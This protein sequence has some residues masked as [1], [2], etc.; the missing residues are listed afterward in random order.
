MKDL[1][2]KAKA[3]ALKNAISYDGKA[4]QGA[5]ISGLF[6][7]GLK[8][9]DVKEY[10]KDILSAIHEVNELSLDD[11]KI[12]FEKIKEFVSEREI[13][14][15]LIELPNTE[16]VIMRFS[17]SPSGALHIGHALTACLNFDYSEKYDGK[18]YVRI[19]DTNPENI[20]KPAYKLIETD[21]DWLFDGKAEIIIQSDRIEL[22]YKYAKELIDKGSAY[23]C[24]CA[25]EDFKNFVEL[26]EDCPC[27]NNEKEEN[28]MR[29]D[30]MLLEYKA[31]EAV[32]RFKS[33]LGMGDPNPAMRDFPLAR[34][35]E[36]THARQGKKYRV[37]PLMN[38]AVSVDDI[39]LGITHIIRAK[40]HRDNSKRQ[41]MIYKVL[42]KDFPWNGFLGRLH[43]K[44]MRLS[45][46]EIT[47]GVEKGDY[48]GW[49]DPK[50]LTVASLKAKGYSPQAFWKLAE[51]IGL[52]ENDKTLDKK[53]L[54][55]LLNTFNK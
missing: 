31:G 51:H 20:Y 30:K 45:A 52:S 43:L 5:V 50:L 14:E 24:T 1:K 7:E 34:V 10:S 53:D 21:S 35:N 49:D 12:E 33:I 32:L 44:D 41:E 23:I 39:E 22:Y 16:K 29:W 38:L 9:E 19:E 15:G 42:E 3:Y 55:E 28:L 36:N 48:S 6:N 18:F 26:K 2:D 25:S 4:S 37:W 54:F 40:E 11:Q 27:R 46:S 13:R 47:E 8:K 17:P